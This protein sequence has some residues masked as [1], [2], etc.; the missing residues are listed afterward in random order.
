MLIR[1]ATS[2][3][4]VN[5]GHLFYD[6]ITHVNC[7]DYSSAQVEAWRAGWQNITGWQ[8]KIQAQYFLV[9]EAERDLCGF[10]SLATD[11]YL[12]FLFV[13]SQHQRQGIAKRLLMALLV[14]AQ[15][16]KLTTIYTDAS[17]TAQPFF[18][19]YGFAVEREQ[20]PVLRGVTLTNFRMTR[21]VA[22]VSPTHSIS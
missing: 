3:D 16:L 1:R 2:T 17:Y 18:T 10:A 9:A 12:D 22:A 19:H 21:P 11:G 8:A 15:C 20:Q 13:S 7:V 6:T 14:Q 4:A 5:I